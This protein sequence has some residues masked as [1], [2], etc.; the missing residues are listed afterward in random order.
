MKHGALRVFTGYAG[1]QSMEF[2]L[3]DEIVWVVEF[4]FT[5]DEVC[6]VYKV[7]DVGE[8]WLSVWLIEF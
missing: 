4:K 1:N 2:W 7:V 5:T 8:F 3:H 6:Q